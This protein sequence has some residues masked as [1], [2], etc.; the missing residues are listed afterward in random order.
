MEV[1]DDY[2]QWFQKLMPGKNPLATG[3]DWN[4]WHGKAYIYDEYYHPTAWLGR[5]VS[6]FILNYSDP[7]PFFIKAS[8]H[9]PHSPYDPPARVLNATLAADLP[10]MVVGKGWDEKFRNCGGGKDAWCGQKPADQTEMS[11]RCYHASV[12]FVDEHVGVILSAL[13]KK[14]LFENTFILFTADHGDGQSDHWHWRKGY[15]YEFSSH[16][17]M[18]VRWPKSMEKQVKMKRG[19]TSSFVVEL[20]DV[21]PTF[22]SVAGVIPPP[23]TTEG[24]SVTCLLSDPSG[25]SCNW[26]QWLDL[27]HSICYNATNHWNALTDGKMKYIFNAYDA[28]E[29]LF[30]LTAD[31]MERIELSENSD[32]K[33]ELELWRGRMVAQF[34]REGRGP[35]WVQNG[36]LIARPTGQTYSPNYP[37]HS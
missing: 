5:R 32:Y 13:K 24:L 21:F 9:R 6:N 23:N 33:K 12:S 18:I 7:R 22:L 16:V 34:E 37:H 17:P 28:D 15:P 31:P 11:R 20:R 3:L 4:T 36:T 10:P 19:S 29:Q 27:E 30:N 35:K 26:R 14:N 8:F 1:F 25:K 2:D